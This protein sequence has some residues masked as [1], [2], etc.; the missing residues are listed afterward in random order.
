VSFLHFVVTKRGIES[1]QHDGHFGGQS[2]SLS[3][4][5]A[6]CGSVGNKVITMISAQKDHS[7]EDVAFYS[8]VQ[9]QLARAARRILGRAPPS[10]TL[11]PTLL[12]NEAWIVFSKQPAYLARDRVGIQC[13]IPSVMRSVLVTYSRTRGAVKRGGGVR[14]EPIENDDATC[15]FEVDAI[16]DLDQAMEDLRLHHPRVCRVME[17]RIY[18]GGDAAEIAKL[19]GLAQRSV[20]RDVAFGKKALNLYLRKRGYGIDL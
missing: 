8:W 10:P 17:M 4:R 14:P 12:A 6:V 11:Q 9:Q 16:L 19:L 2:D 20:D 15:D 7:N 1:L 18:G 5:G 13:L 3:S